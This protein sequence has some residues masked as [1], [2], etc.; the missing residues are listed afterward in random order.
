[1]AAHAPRKAVPGK[2]GN[3]ALDMGADADDSEFERF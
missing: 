2:G 3:I 1:V